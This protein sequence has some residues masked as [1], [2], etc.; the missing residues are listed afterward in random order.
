MHRAAR[1]MT[2]RPLVIDEVGHTLGG[3]EW[4]VVDD[5]F[6]EVKVAFATGDLRQAPDELGDD[7]VQEAVDA[8][9]A[10]K[11]ANGS[12]KRRRSGSSKSADSEPEEA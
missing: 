3:G 10:A 6:D 1:N 9:K 12:S 4:G 8:V 2:D 11:E 5:R 7:A